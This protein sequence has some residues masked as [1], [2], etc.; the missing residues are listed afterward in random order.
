MPSAMSVYPNK[1]RRGEN[2]DGPSKYDGCVRIPQLAWLEFGVK[3]WTP[4]H[5]GGIW[6][7]SSEDGH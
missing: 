1:M 7:V 4:V 5:Y 6:D 2:I 3:S